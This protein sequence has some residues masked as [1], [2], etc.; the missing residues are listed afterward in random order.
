MHWNKPFKTLNHF[1]M[2]LVVFTFSVAAPNSVLAEGRNYETLPVFKASAILPPDL[3]KSS[4]HKVDETVINDGYVNIYKIQSP[5]GEFRAVSTETL[6]IRVH[7]TRAIA[8]MEEVEGTREFGKAMEKGSV[9]IIKS[10]VNIVQHPVDSLTGA[11]S[12]VSKAFERTEEA[13]FGGRTSQR[14]DDPLKSMIGL[15]KT[16]REYA[17][18]FDVDVYSSNA[19]LQEHL[20]KIAW[21][22]Y[23]GGMSVTAA[24]AAIPGAAGITVSL[25][26]TSHMLN[27][28]ISDSPPTDLRIMNRDKLLAMDVDPDIAELFINNTVFSPRHQTILVSVLE[29]MKHTANRE[30]FVKFAILTMDEDSAFFRQRMAQLYAG[31]NDKVAV[32]KQ[33]AT[34]AKLAVGE[35]AKGRLIIAAPVD[36]L[37]WTEKIARLFDA[38]HRYTS[39]SSEL[40]E[41]ALWVTGSVSDLSRKQLETH[42][43]KIFEACGT[44]L[45]GSH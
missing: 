30:G 14:E 29:K 12:G 43:W 21:A 39:T 2:V 27:D 40:R 31:Y 20:E 6:K 13:F 3:L 44:L 24:T 32:I 23:A 37:V 45:L 9:D 26:G 22:G 38:I 34:V 25:F 19:V 41:K 15:S 5:F 10:A 28:I 8:A 1:M 36:H 33:F 18:K 17:K 11:L 42:G 16:K 4:L 7:E 35:D